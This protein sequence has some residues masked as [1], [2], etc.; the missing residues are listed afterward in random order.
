MEGNF[1]KKTS[2]KVGVSSFL[3]LV[4]ALIAFSIYIG[5]GNSFIDDNYLMTFVFLS[6]IL[7][8]IIAFMGRNNRLG[9]FT[10]YSSSILFGFGVVFYL[11]MSLIWNQP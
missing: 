8:M 11:I 1:L 5:T 3:V 10:L 2:G 7:S 9:K 4:L 6:L